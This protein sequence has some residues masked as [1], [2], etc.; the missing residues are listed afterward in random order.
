MIDQSIS[1][2][3]QRDGKVFIPDFGAFIYS[4]ISDTINFNDLLTF[5]DGKLISE[6][7]KKQN[8]PEEEARDVLNEYI[9]DTKSTINQGNLHF[10]EGI[11]YLAKDPQGVFSIQETLSS[12]DSAEDVEIQESE[13]IDMNEHEDQVVDSTELSDSDPEEKNIDEQYELDTKSFPAVD[14]EQTNNDDL[15]TST[16]EDEISTNLLEDVLDEEQADDDDFVTATSEEEISTDT[17]EVDLYEEQTKDDDFATA[18]FEDELSI[19]TYES[20][21]D[22]A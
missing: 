6:I 4:E 18:T 12:P 15:T 10:I 11:G 17:D 22:V 1:E 19:D 21:L 20:D 13:S 16:T 5:D 2:I 3:Y 9:E 14:E 7:Q 8:L